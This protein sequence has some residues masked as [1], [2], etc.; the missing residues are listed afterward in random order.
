MYS[1]KSLNWASSYWFPAVT[2]ERKKKG[3]ERGR[4]EG[5][6]KVEKIKKKKLKEKNLQTAQYIHHLTTR[7]MTHLQPSGTCFRSISSPLGPS[8]P[9]TVLSH[10]LLGLCGCIKTK[11][12]KIDFVLE[13]HIS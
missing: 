12:I 10:M 2:V 1:M 3:R 5:E 9:T 6:E 8:S 13:A 11:L 7:T 4:S